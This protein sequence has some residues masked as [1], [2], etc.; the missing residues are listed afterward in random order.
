MNQAQTWR[1]CREGGRP[2]AAGVFL[3]SGRAH[4][5]SVQD[6]TATKGN[7]FED[8]FLKRCV[9]VLHGFINA[10]AALHGQVL[11]LS[12]SAANTS[13]PPPPPSCVESC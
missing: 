11:L 6:V 5:P 13:P 9:H 3:T 4:P 2:A 8:Y 12:C 1:N 10:M 7:S